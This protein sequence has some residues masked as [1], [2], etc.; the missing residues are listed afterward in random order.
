MEQISKR[1]N[2]ACFSDE[3]REHERE[4]SAHKMSQTFLRNTT[5]SLSPCLAFP[6][7]ARKI[8]TANTTNRRQNKSTALN[9][10]DNTV[11]LAS[12]SVSNR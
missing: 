9:S 8:A 1:A 5:T 2:R 6:T 3:N 12:G 4:Q 11:F 7:S 10:A